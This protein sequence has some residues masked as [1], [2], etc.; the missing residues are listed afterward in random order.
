[1]T[2]HRRFAVAFIAFALGHQARS[3]VFSTSDVWDV[4]Q[5]AVVTGVSGWSRW[6]TQNTIPNVLGGSI[7]PV[8]PI[9]LQPWPG[10]AGAAFFAE[11]LPSGTIHWLEWTTP[12]PVT[13]VG[14]N[15]FANS[16]NNPSYPGA[17]GFSNFR[18]LVQNPTTLSYDLVDSFAT[19]SLDYDLVFSRNFAPVTGDHFRAEFTQTAS[20]DNGYVQGPRVRELDAIAVPEPTTTVA[21]TGLMLACV[22]AYRRYPRGNGLKG[23]VV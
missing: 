11:D 1:M 18:L 8:S 4:S 7:V 9:N 3:Q 13:V 22:A 5:G 14:Y 21:V 10:E 12:S 2:S 6:S 19:G 17:R 15:L 16:D 20:A 23:T